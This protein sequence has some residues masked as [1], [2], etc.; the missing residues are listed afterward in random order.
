MKIDDDKITMEDGT[1][2]YVNRGIIGLG[3]PDE[4]EWHIYE[5]YDGD[6]WYR[7]SWATEEEYEDW[8]MPMEHALEIASHMINRWQ[9]FKN[10]WLERLK[11][12]RG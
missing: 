4:D 12:D 11:S 5:G 10:H 3:C 2:Y 8:R 7:Y 1:E 9:A 6:L